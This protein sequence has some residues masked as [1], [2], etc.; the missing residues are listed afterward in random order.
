VLVRLAR[1]D[2]SATA[3]HD[4][5]IRAATTA[6]DAH[7]R[8]G[9]ALEQLFVNSAQPENRIYLIRELH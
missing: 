9:L 3:H 4:V 7:M 2:I 5:A 8:G 1:L 6:S